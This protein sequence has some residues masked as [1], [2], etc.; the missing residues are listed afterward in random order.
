MRDLNGPIREDTYSAVGAPDV[1]FYVALAQA[2]GLVTTD[3]FGAVAGP[4]VSLK[5]YTVAAGDPAF[6]PLLKY[7]R[8][9]GRGVSVLKSE[10]DQGLGVPVYRSA[11]YGDVTAYLKQAENLG[12]VGRTS[13]L[14]QSY[15]LAP[16]WVN[17]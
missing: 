5:Y 17:G 14:S 13:A 11:G 3:G 8:V 9:K 10:I 12:I 2:A 15:W 6:D 16:A 4:R 7:L 1:P